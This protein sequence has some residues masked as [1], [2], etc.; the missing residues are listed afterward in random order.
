[1]CITEGNRGAV[2]SIFTFV[3]MNNWNISSVWC[4]IGNAPLSYCESFGAIHGLKWAMSC[5]A[6]QCI[7]FHEPIIL[8][9][10]LYGA[11]GGLC[12]VCQE[13]T[14]EAQ[15]RQSCGRSQV[16]RESAYTDWY[17]Q[18]LWGM[19]NN[20]FGTATT[21]L[22]RGVQWNFGVVVQNKM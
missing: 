13:N 8:L 11:A 6:K 9:F 19:D 4:N 10:L 2:S 15:F 5:S 16:E 12:Q 18:P 21:T 1:M 17:R 22:Y 7:K 3:V 20:P 14:H